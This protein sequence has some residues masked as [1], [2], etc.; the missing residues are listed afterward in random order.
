MSIYTDW[1]DHMRDCDRCCNAIKG[2]FPGGPDA[3]CGKC[4]KV[5]APLYRKYD[6]YLRGDR[7][8]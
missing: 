2:R 7:R 5:G 6:N 1:K 4:C 3:I 8:K